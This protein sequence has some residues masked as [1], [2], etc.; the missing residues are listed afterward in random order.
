MVI[1]SKLPSALSFA[2]ATSERTRS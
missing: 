2:E 1:N